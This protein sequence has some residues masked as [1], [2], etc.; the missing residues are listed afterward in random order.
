MRSYVQALTVEQSHGD[1]SVVDLSEQPTAFSATVGKLELLHGSQRIYQVPVRS[2]KSG[3]REHCMCRHVHEAM[4]A[5][6][7]QHSTVHPTVNLKFPHIG[8][9][10]DVPV[11]F[12]RQARSNVLHTV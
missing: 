5:S 4:V 7:S 10:T 2:S 11:M 3:R 9:L 12:G 1:F 8:N 6:V